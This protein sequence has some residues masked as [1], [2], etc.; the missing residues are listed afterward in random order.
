MSREPIDAAAIIDREVEAIFQ[1]VATSFANGGLG[2]PTP[3]E[4]L[5]HKLQKI[6]DTARRQA[7]EDLAGSIRK[8]LDD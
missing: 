1:L 5:T 7:K 8:V 3:R 6:W 4:Q 2:H